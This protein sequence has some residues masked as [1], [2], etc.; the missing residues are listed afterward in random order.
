MQNIPCSWF[1]RISIVKISILPTAIYRISAIPNKFPRIIFREIEQKILNFLWNHKR[2]QIIK[3]I[4]TKKTQKNKKLEVSHTDFKLYYRAM[5]IKT[6]WSLQKN[7]Y[8]DKWIRIKT[9]DKN[10]RCMDN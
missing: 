7:K 8:I 9:P 1:R 4:L 3:V 6:A 5:V 2:P 10:H